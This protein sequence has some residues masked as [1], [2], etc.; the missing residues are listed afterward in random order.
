MEIVI[1]ISV[2]DHAV[3]DDIYNY[4]FWHSFPVFPG[5]SASNLACFGVLPASITYTFFSEGIYLL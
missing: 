4:T 1:L 2:I 5:P 3:M